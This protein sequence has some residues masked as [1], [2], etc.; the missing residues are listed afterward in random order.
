MSAIAFRAAATCLTL[1]LLSNCKEESP[2]PCRPR[3]T[4]LTGP[5][6]GSA[7]EAVC[8][9]TRQTLTLETINGALVARCV[10][11]VVQVDGG[12]Q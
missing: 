2:P 11:A 9:D 4:L 3:V 6:W 8:Y 12:A 5:G 1:A 7:T 10:C